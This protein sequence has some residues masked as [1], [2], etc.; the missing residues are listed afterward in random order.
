VMYSCSEQVLEMI[1]YEITPDAVTTSG[2]SAVWL[3]ARYST[4]RED[5]TRCSQLE[6]LFDGGA[7]MHHYSGNH[8][9]LLHAAAESGNVDVMMLLL[10][11]G[12]V[13][14][15]NSEKYRTSYGQTPLHCAAQGGHIAMVQLLLNK[16]CNRK[17][18]NNQ[19]NTA[20]R[21]CLQGPRDDAACYQSLVR[22]GAD[23]NDVSA[24]TR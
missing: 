6:D 11:R 16:G 1:S 8:G 21:L 19:G 4:Q 24:G 13:L 12:L 2:C 23:A 3:A 17:E 14:D 9:S 7:D 5:Y 10:N 22:A 15:S 20:L 18:S